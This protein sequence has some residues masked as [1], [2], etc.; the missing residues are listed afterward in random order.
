M[1]TDEQPPDPDPARRVSVLRCKRC[2]R[3]SECTPAD[4]SHYAQNGWP[5]CCGE[6]MELLLQSSPDVDGGRD[7]DS[8]K[9]NPGG[10]RS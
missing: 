7:A 10:Q 9:L 8:F 1:T 3:T 6:V 2:A 4:Q 5:R